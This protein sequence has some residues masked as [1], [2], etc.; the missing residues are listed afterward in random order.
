VAE[1]WR[2]AYVALIDDVDVV[3]TAL[4]DM[5]KVWVFVPAGTVTLEGT[6]ATAVL[7]LV[8]VTTAPPEA[9]GDPRVTVPVEVFVP[10]TVVG[11]KPIAKPAEATVR[12]ACAE[13]LL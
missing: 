9:A 10:T 3:A 6:V 12:V 13:V 2:E 1:A 8:R 4:V 5:V 7:L 11:F